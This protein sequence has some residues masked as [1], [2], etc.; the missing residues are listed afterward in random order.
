MYLLIGFIVL[1]LYVIIGGFLAAITR[2]NEDGLSGFMIFLWPLVLPIFMLVGLG[3]W[4]M[5]LGDDLV[6]SFYHL[7]NSIK[8]RK[9]K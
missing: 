4:A 6:K 5:N 7:K 8:R 1:C 3:E 2:F 9:S